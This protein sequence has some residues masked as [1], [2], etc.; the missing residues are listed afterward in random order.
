MLLF[1]SLREPAVLETI[2]HPLPGHAKF[3]EDALCELLE[4]GRVVEVSC[5]QWWLI[6]C[7]FPL[8]PLSKRFKVRQ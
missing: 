8:K 6:R 5:L 3:V 1:L 4:S 2:D 7:Q